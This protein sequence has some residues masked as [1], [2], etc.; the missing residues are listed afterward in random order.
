M[1]RRGGL[2][3]LQVGG[4]GLAHIL[5]CR[6]NCLALR[7]AAG[8]LRHVSDVAVVFRVEDQVHEELAGLSRATILQQ[9]SR[10]GLGAS[11][12][13]WSGDPCETPSFPRKRESSA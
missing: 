2:G 9:M 13:V 3:H 11:G 5:Q 4:D 7:H 10:Y 6:F 8:E 12:V 1:R